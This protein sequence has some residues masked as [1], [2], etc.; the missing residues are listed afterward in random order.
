MLEETPIVA[1]LCCPEDVAAIKEAVKALGIRMVFTSSPEV[2]FRGCAERGADALIVTLQRWEVTSSDV[3]KLVHRAGRRR[4]VI[5]VAP[6]AVYMR[7]REAVDVGAFA[8]LVGR[9]QPEVLEGILRRALFE[10]AVQT[11]EQ[12]RPILLRYYR[13]ALDVTDAFEVRDHLGRCE[14]CRATLGEIAGSSKDAS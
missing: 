4:P 10:P 5:V 13:R 1:A 7:P 9:P 8:L 12:A 3:W 14:E 2:F 6:V 11:C